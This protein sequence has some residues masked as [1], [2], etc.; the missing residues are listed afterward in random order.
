MLWVFWLCLI[1]TLTYILSEV[2]LLFAI[3]NISES[4]K[5]HHYRNIS[6]IIAAKNEAENLK[7][8]LPFILNQSYPN[9]EVIAVDDH[10]KDESK[11]V[12]KELQAKNSHLRVIENQSESSKKKAIKKGIKAAKYD[13][14]VFTDADCKPISNDWLKYMNSQCLENNSIILGYSPYT[15]T[16][17]WINKIIR[18]ETYKTALNYF[19]FAKLG[20]AYM[21]VGRNLAY[22]KAIFEELKGFESHKLV[23]SGDDDLFVNQAARKYAVRCCL[24]QESFVQSEPKHNLK[25]WVDQKRRHIST[26][27]HYNFKHQ[28][29]LTFQFM[30]KFLFWFFVLPFSIY[31]FILNQHSLLVLVIFSGCF[32]MIYSKFVY[33][34]LLVQDLWKTSLILE[35]QLICLQLYIFG[36]N[37]FSPKKDW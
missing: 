22:S 13:V 21:G 26:A 17:A 5:N 23:L 19:G 7:Q 18:F 4:S 36:L 20:S 6:V 25:D 8:F 32:K 34:K 11:Q 14:L 27:N 2:T 1:I 30:L 35:F 3:R 16:K 33:S 31:F 37:L 15:K 24:N 9:F 10:S 12:L 29:I 28:L